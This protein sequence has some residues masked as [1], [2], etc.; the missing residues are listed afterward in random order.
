M[1]IHITTV[2]ETLGFLRGQIGYM[3]ARGLAVHAVSSPGDCLDEAAS[4]E[5]ITVHAVAMSRRIA[6]LADLL[7]LSQLFRLFRR[8]RPAIVHAHTP[9]AGLLGV[10]A[11]RLAGVPVVLY[12]MRGLPFVT[13]TGLKRQILCWSETVAC[14]LAH[15]IITNSLANRRCALAQGFCRPGKIHVLGGGSSNGVDAAGRFNP[16]GLPPGAREATRTWCRVP[17]GCKVLGYVGRLVRDKGI[18]ELEEAW[19]QVRAV[20]PDLYLLLVGRVEPQDPVPPEVLARLA[21]DPRVR[22]AGPVQDPAPYYA[23][24]D[25]LALPSYREG[26]PNTPLE[27]AAMRVPV[28]ATTAD[29]GAEAVV[30]GVTGLLVP[31]RDAAALGEAI[32]RLLLDHNLRQRMGAAGR[33]R[34]LKDFRPEVIWQALFEIYAELLGSPGCQTFTGRPARAL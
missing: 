15:R 23:A 4:R 7:A 1:L 34:V 9:K 20:F 31:P 24:M 27:A 2:P 33:D 30:H 28:I 19:R 29:G 26:F 10:A 11:A 17:P 3:Q 16:A 14:R 13:A 18:K 22:F 32:R 25:V 8:L 6:P 5:Q 21:A 12:G